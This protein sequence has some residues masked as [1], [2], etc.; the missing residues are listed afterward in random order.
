MILLFAIA[1][2][3]GGGGGH[4]THVTPPTS[5]TA[6]GVYT[7]AVKAMSGSTIIETAFFL[8]VD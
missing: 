1:P 5:G 2:G 7:I 8:T 3:C 4:S 6:K